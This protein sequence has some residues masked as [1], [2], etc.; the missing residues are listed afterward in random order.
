MQKLLLAKLIEY[1]YTKDKLDEKKVF[2]IASSLTRKDLKLYIKTLKLTE[3][4]KK[5]YIAVP[6]R[7]VYNDGRKLFKGIFEGKEII[8]Q[9]DPSLLLGTRIVDNDM[10]YDTSLKERIG[11]IEDSINDF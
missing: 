3:Q 7:S 8:L 11:E 9:E 2:K 10:V 5:V 4:K 1:S 6:H